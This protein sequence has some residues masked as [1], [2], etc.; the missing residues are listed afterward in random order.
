MRS[1]EKQLESRILLGLVALVLLFFLGHFGGRADRRATEQPPLRDDP[2]AS[3]AGSNYDP[4]PPRSDTPSA[5]EWN[6]AAADRTLS[7]LVDARVEFVPDGDSLEVTLGGR[8]ERVR[9]AGI[10]TPEHG[11]PFADEAR[12]YTRAWCQGR[13]VQLRPLGRDRYGRLLADVYV[14]GANLNQ[15]LLVAGW[16]WSYDREEAGLMAL[17]AAARKARRGLWMDPQPIRPSDWRQH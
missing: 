14:A 7:D 11:Q 4:A 6:G 5:I 13:D 1:P 17:E 10:D 15:A 3:G 16:A 8:A 2:A 12:D 9:L